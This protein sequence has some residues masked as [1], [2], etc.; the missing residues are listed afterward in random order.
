MNVS[1]KVSA[2]INKYHSQNEVTGLDLIGLSGADR[3]VFYDFL[4][5]ANERV[6]RQAVDALIAH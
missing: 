5:P 2:L 1:H 3:E 4:S 6:A